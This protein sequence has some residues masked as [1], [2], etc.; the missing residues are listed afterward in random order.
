MSKTTK[1]LIAEHWLSL[2]YLLFGNMAN[3]VLD[4]DTCKKYTD[5]KTALLSNVADIYKYFGYSKTV[6]PYNTVEEMFDFIGDRVDLVKEEVAKIIKTPKHIKALRKE[7]ESLSESSDITVQ[8]II[9]DKFRNYSLDQL[10]LRDCLDECADP[11]KLEKYNFKILID[12]HK[13]LRSELI[14]L[15]K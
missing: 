8:S 5:S 2:D 13:I 14:D 1:K 9:S 12:A 15:V 6:F 7:V 11:E 3:K 10:L 4:E